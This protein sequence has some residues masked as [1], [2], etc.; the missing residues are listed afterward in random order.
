MFQ[1]YHMEHH[2]Y[3]GVEGIDTDVPSRW[4]G[5]FFTNTLMKIIWVIIQP[6][7][8]ITRPLY[9]KPKKPGFWEA[10]NWSAT[11]LTD[12]LV[13]IYWGPKS[14]LYLLLSAALGERFCSLML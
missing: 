9:T 5:E 12:I 10:M 8:Y 6:F 2:Q 4:E 1:R 3:Q 7:F 14:F 13:T 11:I